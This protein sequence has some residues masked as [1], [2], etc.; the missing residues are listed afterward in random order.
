MRNTCIEN[1]EHTLEE[2]IR[3]TKLGI[4]ACDSYGGQTGEQFTF[5]AGYGIM[6][7]NGQLEE[8]VRDLTVSGNVFET[9]ANIDM[10][11]NDR[12]PQDSGGGCG[13][14]IQYPLPVSSWSAS[15]RV[16]NV[17]VGGQ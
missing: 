2:M 9:L 13:K 1:G 8:M 12:K 15:F 16:N 4:Y 6:I 11:A 14:G 17:I 5:T 3:D 7:R 10:I